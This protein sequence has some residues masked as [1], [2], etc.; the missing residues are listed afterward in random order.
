MY[1]R[2]PGGGRRGFIVALDVLICARCVVCGPVGEAD[3]AHREAASFPGAVDSVV[4]VLVVAAEDA[5]DRNWVVG[6]CV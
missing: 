5:V 1:E 2:L 3:A 4:A 6:M